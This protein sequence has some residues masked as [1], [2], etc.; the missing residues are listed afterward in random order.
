MRYADFGGFD[1]FETA[2]IRVR[3]RCKPKSDSLLTAASGL[4]MKDCQPVR[5]TEHPGR[6][7]RQALGQVISVIEESVGGIA[8]RTPLGAHEVT[9]ADCLNSQLEER[10]ARLECRIVLRSEG[11]RSSMS[12]PCRNSRH[13]YGSAA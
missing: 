6:R 4:T 12:H 3:A 7:G 10:F 11:D 2:E 8:P 9:I 13:Q 1:L 5:Q